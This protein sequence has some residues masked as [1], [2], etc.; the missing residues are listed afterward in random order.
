[1]GYLGEI[2]QLVNLQKWHREN[3]SSSE[4]VPTQQTSGNLVEVDEE[5]G[6][7]NNE[8]DYE[9]VKKKTLTWSTYVKWITLPTFLFDILSHTLQIVLFHKNK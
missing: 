2:T 4:C 7:N 3:T 5:C 6:D 9:N 1:M 8:Y